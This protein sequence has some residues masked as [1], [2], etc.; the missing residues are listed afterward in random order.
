MNK[1]QAKT[2]FPPWEDETP[3]PKEL[4]EEVNR[5]VIEEIGEAD[6]FFGYS[7]NFWAAKK[8]ILREQ[9]G[10]DWKTPAERYPGLLI[11]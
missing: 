11:D 3:L 10:I 7:R 9:Y 1:Q 8:R 2:P 5:Q 6:Y 4:E